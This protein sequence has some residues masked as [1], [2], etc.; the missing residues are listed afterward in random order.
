MFGPVLKSE[1]PQYFY[2]Y[3]FQRMVVILRGLLDFI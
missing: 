1:V 3:P 2:T